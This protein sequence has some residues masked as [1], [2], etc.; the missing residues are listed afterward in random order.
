MQG[1]LAGAQTAK[2][3]A[4]QFEPRVTDFKPAGFPRYLPRELV[5][6]VEGVEA[7]RLKLSS[8]RSKLAEAIVEAKPSS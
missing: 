1:R 4:V 6:S 2:M 7:V 3:Q 5:L 8:A